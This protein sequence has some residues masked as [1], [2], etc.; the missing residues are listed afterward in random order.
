MCATHTTS[1]SRHIR[2]LVTA[3]SQ[4]EHATGIRYAIITPPLSAA[5]RYLFPRIPHKK[6]QALFFWGGGGVSVPVLPQIPTTRQPKF[7]K[8]ANKHNSRPQNNR[9]KVLDI[10]IIWASPPVYYDK[11]GEP[12]LVAGSAST[13][14]MRKGG[15]WC[16]ERSWELPLPIPCQADN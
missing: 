15:T 2:A 4:D 7:P 10:T 12:S 8:F 1:A 9:R 13:R 5:S 14:H 11:I 6:K 16:G 3:P